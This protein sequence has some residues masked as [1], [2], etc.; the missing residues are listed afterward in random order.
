MPIGACVAGPEAAEVLGPGDHGSTFAAGPWSRRRRL[1]SSTWST[2]RRCCA[3]CGSWAPRCVTGWRPSTGCRGAGAGPDDGVGLEDGVDAAAVGA[4]LLDRGLVVNVPAAGSCGCCRRWWSRPAQVAPAVGL[5][6]ESLRKLFVSNE[7]QASLRVLD[8][9]ALADHHGGAAAVIVEAAEKAARERHRRRRGGGA[10]VSRRGP[11]RGRQ[12]R[13]RAVRRVAEELDPPASA[14]RSAPHRGRSSLRR[15]RRRTAPPRPC[16]PHRLRRGPPARDPDGGFR[17]Q[18]GGDR[19]AA[20]KWL[21]DRG[22]QRDPRRDTRT[23]GVECTRTRRVDDG[24]RMTRTGRGGHAATP[25]SL[26]P[27]PVR[28]DR[29]PGRRDRAR[30]STATATQLLVASTAVETTT[31]AEHHRNHDDRQEHRRHFDDEKEPRRR[32]TEARRRT[33]TSRRRNGRSKPTT[34]FDGGRN[35]EAAG[36]RRH[37]APERGCRGEIDAR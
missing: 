13:C 35:K 37:S 11:R 1:P 17:L 18:P 34:T 15:P 31:V 27:G 21:R 6:G 36:S 19:G 5:I 3:G 22:R 32:R 4:D 24:T 33:R 8:R 30:S 23:R 9:G 28:G 7:P 2:T 16:A 25:A 29:R 20:A 26:S 14:P 12:D 10:P